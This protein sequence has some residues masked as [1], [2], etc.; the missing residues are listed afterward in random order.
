MDTEPEQRFW[1]EF[2][3]GGWRN[4]PWPQPK[5]AEYQTFGIFYPP[6]RQVGCAAL[7][8]VMWLWHSPGAAAGGEVPALGA[9][10]GEFSDLGSVLGRAAGTIPGQLSV[11][12]QDV[13][14]ISTMLC[15]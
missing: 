10:L 4:E 13:P 3:G 8:K 15:L 1:S 12:S 7:G 2:H 9:P 14:R 11:H 6:E 5:A